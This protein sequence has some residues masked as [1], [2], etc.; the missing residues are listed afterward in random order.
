MRQCLEDLEINWEVCWSTCYYLFILENSVSV[1]FFKL[2][3]LT[4][5][6]FIHFFYS[7]VTRS[8]FKVCEQLTRIVT[9][10]I[11]IDEVTNYYELVNGAFDQL[12]LH[13]S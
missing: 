1:H 2:E 6:E 8:F 3:L 11:S 4:K 13:H 9:S 12:N 7:S 5:L 10:K